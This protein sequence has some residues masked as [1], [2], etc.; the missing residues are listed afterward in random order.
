MFSAFYLLLSNFYF[1]ISSLFQPHQLH[2][3]VDLRLANEASREA[4]TWIT[5]PEGRG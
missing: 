1:P 4:A 3:F 2:R 5:K